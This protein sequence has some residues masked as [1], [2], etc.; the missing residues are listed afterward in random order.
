MNESELG[1]R[2]L[3]IKSSS[4]FSTTGYQ[5]RPEK[6]D[7]SPKTKP[8]YN[9]SIQDN[10]NNAKIFIGNLGYDTTRKDIQEFFGEFGKIIEIRLGQFEDTGKCKGFCHLIYKKPES[11]IQVIESF[12]ADKR[13]FNLLGQKIRVEFGKKSDNGTKNKRM[14][15]GKPA[16][17]DISG[18]NTKIKFDETVQESHEIVGK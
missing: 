3:L 9:L 12:L 8:Q 5:P 1:G 10:E 4:D 15:H 18:K 2:N 16:F 7:N 17:A 11:A 13:Q 6:R 14:R